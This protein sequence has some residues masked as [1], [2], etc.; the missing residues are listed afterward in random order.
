MLLSLACP[1][2]WA[3]TQA[4]QGADGA[5]ESAESM[6]PLLLILLATMAVFLS[7]RLNVG[8]REGA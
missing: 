1:E 8:I 6:K 2:G 7:Y 5:Q 3:L 4:T